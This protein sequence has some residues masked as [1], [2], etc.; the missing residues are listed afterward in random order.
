MQKKKKPLSLY[1]KTLKN[2]WGEMLM[3]EQK[4]HL[5]SMNKDDKDSY[6]Y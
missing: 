4:N 5:S 3:I 1:E 6:H 2:T